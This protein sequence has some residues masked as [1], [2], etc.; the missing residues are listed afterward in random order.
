MPKFRQHL[1]IN[2]VTLAAIDIAIQRCEIERN[3]NQKFDWAR[4]AVSVGAGAIAGALPDILEPSLGN[5]NH[6]G[7]CHSLA[8][9]ITVWWIVSGRHTRDL[10]VEVRRILTAVG[11]G[12]GLHLGA[13]LFFSKAKGMGLI[14][15]QF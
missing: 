4:F 11:I 5:P 3:P 2:T 15:A 6:R 14:N 12:Y 8:A 1:T 13:D 7:F 9:A 10:P